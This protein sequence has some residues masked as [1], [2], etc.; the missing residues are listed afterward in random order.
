MVVKLLRRLVFLVL[1]MGTTAALTGA[2]RADSVTPGQ[3]NQSSNSETI[4]VPPVD[5]T[6]NQT[7]DIIQSQTLNADT[8]G[9]SDSSSASQSDLTTPVISNN[10]VV[11]PSAYQPGASVNQVSNTYDQQSAQAG[12]VPQASAPRAVPTINASYQT[13]HRAFPQTIKSSS[14]SAPVA[15][16]SAPKAPAAPTNPPTLPGGYGQFSALLGSVTAP[17]G[18]GLS[19]SLLL[20]GTAVSAMASISLLL[21]VVVM[22]LTLAGQFVAY[23]RRSG[24]IHAA[25]SDVVPTLN[26]VTPPKVSLNSA[27]WALV[28][29]TF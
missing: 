10:A 26:F 20:G 16:P 25:R 1:A 7:T 29:L 6:V 13:T 24:Y 15:A 3:S 9:P 22:S 27:P 14:G 21:I 8:S 12:V 17:S 11:S 18:G 2:A 4:V 23:L 19:S 28:G 5:P